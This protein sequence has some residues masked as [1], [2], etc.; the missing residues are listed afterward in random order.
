[1]WVVYYHPTKKT[2][3]ELGLTWNLAID[4]ISVPF[5]ESRQRYRSKSWLTANFWPSVKSLEH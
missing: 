3:T 5:E 2:S 1:M 4:W